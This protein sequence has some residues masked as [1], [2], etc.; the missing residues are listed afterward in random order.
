LTDTT[1]PVVLLWGESDFLLREAARRLFPAQPIEIDPAGWDPT[2]LADLATPSL[3]GEPRG[4]LVAESQDLDADALADVARYA[5]APADDAL[6]VLLAAVGARA[7]G[8]PRALARAVGETADV[9]RVAVER[10]ELP[11]WVADRAGSHGLKA[12]PAGVQALIETLGEDPAELDQALIQ[13]FSA[14]PEEGLTPAAVAAQF[15]GFGDRRTWEL[16]DA[17][18]A[19]NLPTALRALA[20]MLEAREEPLM[21][22][23][24]IASRLRDLIRV[25]ALPPRMP[26]G[27]V[28]RAA[29][30]RFDW[31]ARRY[32]EQAR[33]FAP[34]ELVRAHAQVVEADRQLKSGGAGVADEV[35]LETLVVSV[36]GAA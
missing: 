13:L 33:R 22:L 10:R 35:V 11:R 26:Q 18:F 23:G 16:T 15:R 30:L 9:R 20:G 29:G 2:T 32:R 12:S 14:R 25:R 17:A 19:G 3:F 5:E 34:D 31:Q 28:A 36:I 1:A 4:L 21:I 8:P 6:L 7:K 24:G 27:E